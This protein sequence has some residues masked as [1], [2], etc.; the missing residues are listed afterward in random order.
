VLTRHHGDLAGDVAG[1]DPVHHPVTLADLR[2]PL[3]QHEDL[4]GLRALPD[5]P[6]A[7]GEPHLLR[8]RGDPRELCLG[9]HGEQRDAAQQLDGLVPVRSH[10]TKVDPRADPVSGPFRRSEVPGQETTTGG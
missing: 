5:Q 8:D 2:R 1:T 3:Q 6:A 9:A 7:L 10:P 4:L